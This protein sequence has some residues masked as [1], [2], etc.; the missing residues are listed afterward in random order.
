MECKAY[1]KNNTKCRQN[2]IINGYCVIHYR[3]YK[4]TNKKKC[5]N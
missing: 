2:A 4:N 1:T 5:Q 3:M